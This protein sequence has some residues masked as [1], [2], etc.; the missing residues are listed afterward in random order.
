MHYMCLYPWFISSHL[1]Y[2]HLL[3]LVE[4]GQ[5]DKH[6]K[7]TGLVSI[8]VKMESKCHFSFLFFYIHWLILWYFPPPLPFF[9]LC[10]FCPV[11]QPS[12]LLSPYWWFSP[13]SYTTAAVTVVTGTKDQKK[14]RRMRMAAR[15]T[16]TVGRR[17]GES[18]V[19]RGWRW[20]LSRSAGEKEFSDVTVLPGKCTHDAFWQ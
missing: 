5:S 8:L 17:G 16:V 18:A 6:W 3:L 19:S 4:A 13:S 1:F 2:N 11:Y 9:R 14:R 20:R 12:L 7:L 15:V 10:W